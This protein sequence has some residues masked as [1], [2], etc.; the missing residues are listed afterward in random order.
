MHLLPYEADNDGDNDGVLMKLE[1]LFL[2][3]K[4]SRDR[5][6]ITSDSTGRSRS[7]DFCVVRIYNLII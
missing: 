2:L 4:S 6:E 1:T 7:N 5:L 3:P